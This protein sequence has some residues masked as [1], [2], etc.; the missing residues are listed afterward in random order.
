MHISVTD[1]IYTPAIIG[2]CAFECLDVRREAGATVPQG[3]KCLP[4]APSHKLKIPRYL[5]YNNIQGA[6]G[7]DTPGLVIT[8]VVANLLLK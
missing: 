5:R 6:V 4:T 7:G 8:V 3:P 1:L 2:T